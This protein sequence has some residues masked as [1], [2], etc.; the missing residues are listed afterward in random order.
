MRGEGERNRRLGADE[1]PPIGV[2]PADKVKPVDAHVP[3]VRIAADVEHE[4]AAL[5]SCTKKK[6]DRSVKQAEITQGPTTGIA[7]PVS[8]TLRRVEF[9]GNWEVNLTQ[10][11]GLT[12]EGLRSW[13]GLCHESG[14]GVKEAAVP[15]RQ[16]PHT[17]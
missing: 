7:V 16:P 2:P 13:T 3:A 8:T 14:C 15:S 10:G 1:E 6:T 17:F 4:H 5:A 12:D 9:M 11:L